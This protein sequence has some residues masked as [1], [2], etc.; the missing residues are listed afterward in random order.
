MKAVG[1]Y[2]YLPI[3]DPESLLD[4]EL[5]EPQAT[6]RD[7]LV[8][9]KAI[10]VNPVDVKVRA[11][12]PRVETQPRILGW[13]A[14]GVVEAVGEDVSL[15][16]AGDEVYYAG[17]IMRSGSNAEYQLVDERIV[18]RKPRTLSFAEAAALPLTSI[19]AYEAF[20][21]R[22]GIDSGGRDAGQTLLIIGGS[23]GVGSIGIQLAKRAGLEVIATAS[24]PETQQWAR[25]LG[26]DRVIDHRQPLRPQIEGL[27]Y[28]WVDYVAIFNNTDQH[29]DAACDL[30]K[31]QGRLTTIV[32]NTGELKQDQLKRKS[33]TFA[34]EFMFTRSMF[35]THDMVAQHLLLN[36]VSELIDD[37]QLRTTLK[38]TPGSLSAAGL[39]EVHRRIEAGSAIGKYVLTVD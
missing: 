18:G 13:D 39:K 21:D 26:A 11:P 1:L 2:K 7:L 37:G 12:K 33:A 35:Q 20:F 3:D 5:P 30:I 29:W 10:S 27:G 19:T 38:E 6:G 22:L 8:R 4:L 17:S 25:E 32:E 9:V 14:A 36:R 34:W 15:F 23:G 28:Q 24:R 31:P 16:K